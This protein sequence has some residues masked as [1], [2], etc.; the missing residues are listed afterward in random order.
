M[1]FLSCKNAGGN[2]VKK[3]FNAL[4]RVVLTLIMLALLAPLP[5]A[6]AAEGPDDSEDT[7]ISS[8]RQAETLSAGGV[9]H[10][11]NQK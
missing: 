8:P 6:Q 10:L 4:P 5:A 11:R 9:P 3:H 7:A 1:V 2:A